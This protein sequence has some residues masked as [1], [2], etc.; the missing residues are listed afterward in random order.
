MG[1][2]SELPLPAD[3]LALVAAYA[4]NG[5]TPS[6]AAVR[7]HLHAHPWIEDMMAA[8]PELHPGTIVLGAPCLGLDDCRKCSCCEHA[9]LYEIRRRYEPDPRLDNDDD[10]DAWACR[11][12]F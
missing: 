11:S 7:A 3:L 12:V 5:P 10:D 1:V 9:R 2:A 6:A 8:V 4:A